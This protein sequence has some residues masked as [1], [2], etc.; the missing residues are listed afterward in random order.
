VNE[1]V[2]PEQAA[3][4]APGAR[5]HATGVAALAALFLV[6]AA[7]TWQRAGVWATQRALWSDA[8]EKSPAKARVRLSLGYALRREGRY[9]EAIAEY[10]RGLATATDAETA[11]Q[12]RRNLGA[13]LIWAGRNADA[14]AVLQEAL[15]A[16]PGD[17]ELL[18]N[19]G[20]AAL[21]LHDPELAARAAR[22]AVEA[23]EGNG[24]AWNILGSAQQ[25]LGD[26]AG[27]REAF[28]H[29]A[30]LDPD[31]GLPARNLARVLDRLGDAAGACEARRRALGGRLAPAFQAEVTRAL[32]TC[33]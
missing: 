33:R 17:S 25:E 1:P 24:S 32:S 7:L 27:A 22:Q 15:A 28:E 12:L 31:D 10:R 9:D 23:D 3:S 18:G 21:G 19:L 20:S 11:Q 16:R 4:P 26:L 5:R 30:V 29:A 8:A 13:A 6:L 2:Q 14:V